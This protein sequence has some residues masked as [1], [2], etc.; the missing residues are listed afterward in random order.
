[1]WVGVVVM[2]ALLKFSG[3][4]R[5]SG[6]KEIRVLIAHRITVIGKI[7]LIM[8]IGKNFLLST[9]VGVPVGFEDPDSCS[10]I[11][12]IRAS[13]AT[14]NGTIKCKENIRFKVG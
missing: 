8:K 6:L 14:T 7:S 5:C 4:P 1:M 10:R 11:R 13:T 3:S 2:L 12:W 9:L